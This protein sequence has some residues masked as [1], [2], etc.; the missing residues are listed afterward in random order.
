MKAIVCE[1]YGSPDVLKMREVKKPQPGAEEVLV[2]VR[3]ASVN[4]VDWYGMTGLYFAR[5]LSGLLKPKDSS[6][7]TDYAGVVEAVG[8]NVKEFNPGD[9]VYGGSAGTF[10]E[11]ASVRR[12]IAPKPTNLTFEQ[13][14]AVPTAAITALQALRQYGE[15][16]P[17]DR[18]LI[19]GASGGVGTFAIQ[20]AK[21]LGGEVT[22]VCSTA[23]VAQARSLGADDVVDYTK[24]DFTHSEKQYDLLLEIDGNRS[25]FTYR[26]VL[27]PGATFVIIGGSK[28]NIFIGPLGH[29]LGLR[30]S[31][32]RASQKVRFLM[33]NFN[34][35][36][37]AFLTEL[38]EAK[39]IKP[40]ID[41]TY[42]LNEVPEAMRQLGKGHAK[43]KIVI[44]V[45]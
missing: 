41:R 9:E 16:K 13:A 27:K 34:P 8:A 22:A 33:A 20:I 6:V 24:E 10:A 14:A 23:N 26:R 39:K 40:V 38:I 11:Y 43:G 44:R 12:G 32:I 3:A 30:L 31:A 36:D 17:G 28:H 25:W 5:P 19:N 42:T 45:N 29:I 4:P 2:R 18:V 21:A 35:Q 15:M 37:M 1:K 7:G